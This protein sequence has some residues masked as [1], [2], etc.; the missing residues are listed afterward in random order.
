MV[1]FSPALANGLTMP[2][3]RFQAYI[4]RSADGNIYLFRYETL[5]PDIACARK[6]SSTYLQGVKRRLPT[7]PRMRRA[8]AQNEQ[9][10][11]PYTI[12]C[13]QQ[14]LRSRL[15]SDARN[16]HLVL[17]GVRSW[18]VQQPQCVASVNIPLLDENTPERCNWRL[19]RLEG[20][21]N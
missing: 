21:G 3:A 5:I 12:W 18:L 2:A 6:E 15:V 14:Q 20:Q 9:S 16:R 17:A 1:A 8:R 10:V 7:I 19:G 13:L 11:N 4:V